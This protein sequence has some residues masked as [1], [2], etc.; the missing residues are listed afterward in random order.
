MSLNKC[1]SFKCFN[2][3]KTLQGYALKMKQKINKISRWLG[4]RY[5]IKKFKKLK[6]YIKKKNFFQIKNKLRKTSNGQIVYNRYFNHLIFIT[7]GQMKNKLLKWLKNN[8]SFPLDLNK[9]QI[10]NLNKDK[11]TYLGFILFNKFQSY[12]RIKCKNK[13]NI[14][15][16]K[17]TFLFIGIDHLY[18]KNKL[19]KFNMMNKSYKPKPI[20]WY[21][22]LKS[23]NILKKF[24]RKF[25]ML[26]NYYYSVLT[27]PNELKFYCHIYQ[28][29]YLK[30]LACRMQ[31]NINQI[32]IKYKSDLELTHYKI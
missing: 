2:K 9:I 14:W 29:S 31:M 13:L 8:L 17:Y 4:I 5:N 22:N 27:N 32:F 26:I 12:R 28:F 24:K 19:I 18:M 20:I 16:K 6:F 23:L 15:K 11:I 3:L 1:F 21:Y 7:T 25:R 30:T 10:I